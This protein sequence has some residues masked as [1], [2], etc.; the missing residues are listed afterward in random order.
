[1]QKIKEKAIE[2]G[3]LKESSNEDPQALANMVFLS[4]VSTAKE[5]TDVSGRGVGMDSEIIFKRY[6]WRY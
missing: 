3:Q 5:V 6:G 4:G 2:S 1:M